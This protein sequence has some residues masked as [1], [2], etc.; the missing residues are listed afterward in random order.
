MQLT[1]VCVLHF[2]RLFNVSFRWTCRCRP[3]LCCV[4][5]I[6]LVLGEALVVV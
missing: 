6:S 3:R 4:E 2:E 1:T 5:S